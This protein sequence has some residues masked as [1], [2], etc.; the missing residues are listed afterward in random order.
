MSKFE[1]FGIENE[2]IDLENDK[3]FGGD[4][5]NPPKRKKLIKDDGDG[6]SS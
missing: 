6:T 5:L 4:G 2:D 1:D 3:E